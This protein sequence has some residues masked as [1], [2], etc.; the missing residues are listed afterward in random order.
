[1]R[2][3]RQSGSFRITVLA[4]WPGPLLKFMDCFTILPPSSD[5]GGSPFAMPP[6]SSRRV[7]DL[8]CAKKVALWIRPKVVSNIHLWRFPCPWRESLRPAFLILS[9]LPNCPIPSLTTIWFWFRLSERRSPPGRFRIP[10]SLGSQTLFR[11]SG[12]GIFPVS[13]SARGMAS[14]ILFA[15][16]LN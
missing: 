9:H 16:G 7:W 1:M 13:C 10:T 2:C 12:T 11:P 8:G 15:S 3:R 4:N 6:V 5:T 14:V